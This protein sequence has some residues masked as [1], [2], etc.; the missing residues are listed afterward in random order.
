M[1]AIGMFDATTVM[2]VLDVSPDSERQVLV[3]VP[4]NSDRK[5]LGVP[6][7]RSSGISTL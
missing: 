7:L 4:Q 6:F 5:P 1:A 2:L 3:H